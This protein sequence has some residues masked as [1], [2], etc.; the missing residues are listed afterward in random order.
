M[1]L[2]KNIICE[3]IWLDS[4][5]NI[6]SKTK[7]I[8]LSDLFDGTKLNL[9]NFDEQNELFRNIN[10]FIITSCTSYI[11]PDWNFDGSST[12]QN[13]GE[14]TEVNLIPV[15]HYLHPL[16]NYD[17]IILCD[18]KISDDENLYNYRRKALEVFEKYKFH[19][20]WLGLEQEYFIMDPNNNLPI[21]YNRIPSHIKQGNFYCGNDVRF[22]FGREIVELHNKSCLD[23]GIK[24]SGINAE[25]AIGQWEYQIGPIDPI[26]ACDDLIVSRFLLMRIAEKYGY[27]IS[28]EPKILDSWN[29][30]GCHINISS[31]N[32]RN[33][34]CKTAYKE[35]IDA[36]DNLK[37]NHN[38]TI[39]A[40]GVNNHLR[41]T[42][43]HET[44]D[45][46]NF[47]YGI[48]TRNTSVRIGN[49]TYNDKHGYFE[50]RRPAANINPYIAI[51]TL[52][53]D[54]NYKTL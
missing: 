6:R 27:Y 24:I 16:E 51:S 40:Y 30:S 32:M 3:Y 52:I 20:Y 23:I 45:Y 44:S 47:T 2:N 22:N 43:N 18:C 25:V 5:L 21:G 17:Y 12:N 35:I 7:N 10:S 13:V 54:M 31:Q 42:G 28:F 34:S 1:I 11:F 29:G 41:M 8:I 53:N 33:P 15:A 39:H 37:S 36:I 46:N 38:N 26:K 49:K 4:S 14:N 9:L 48:G 50:D 19:K